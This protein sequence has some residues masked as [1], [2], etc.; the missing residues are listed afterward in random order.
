MADQPADRRASPRIAATFRIRLGYASVDSFVEGYAAN[1][2]KGGIFV[3]SRQPRAKGTEIRF[4]LLLKDGSPAIGGTGRVAWARPFDPDKPGERFGMGVQFL[5]LDASGEEVVRAALAWRAKHM[6]AQEAD[7]EIADEGSRET[8]AARPKPEPKPPAAAKPAGPPKPPAAAKPAGPPKPE[9]RPPVAPKPAGP[10]KPEPK[11]PAAPGVEPA[12]V[13]GADESGPGAAP[14]A[15]EPKPEAAPAP[16]RPE[17]PELPEAESRTSTPDGGTT[18]PG[19]AGAVSA[20]G[21]A[22]AASPPAAIREDA[23]PAAGATAGDVLPGWDEDDAAAPRLPDAATAAAVV[24]AKVVAAT[25]DVDAGA[26]PAAADQD[27]IPVDETP[28]EAEKPPA[29]EAESGRPAGAPA[30]GGAV[31]LTFEEALRQR[32]AEDPPPDD[33][34]DGVWEPAE[35]VAPDSEQEIIER[36]TRPPDPAELSTPDLRSADG[37]HRPSDPSASGRARKPGLLGRLFGRKKGAK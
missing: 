13:P 15:I 25:D 3:P 30:G 11:Q 1:I 36:L 5:T 35:A 32:L 10:P 8:P 29:G 17:P 27:A 23:R 34:Y 26:L 20:R 2:S 22:E 33:A 21:A 19:E 12:R 18:A 24:P 31:P 28:P 16:P 37:G 14:T 7:R 6:S 9:P 4:E